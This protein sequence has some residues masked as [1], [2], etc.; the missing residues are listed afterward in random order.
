MERSAPYHLPVELARGTLHRIRNQ[1]AAWQMA[2]L[3]VSVEV[4]DRIDDA[5]QRLARA[6]TTQDAPQA[7]AD[8]AAPCIQASLDIIDEIAA[9]YCQ[10]ALAVRHEP[11]A[12]LATFVAA[13]LGCRPV[14]PNR[15]GVVRDAFNTAVVPLCWSEIEGEDGQ[16]DF[17][18]C[19][20]QIQW[21]R[22]N[23][24]KICGGPLLQFDRTGL[25]DWIQLWDDDFD[26]VLKLAGRWV[27]QIVTRYRGQVNLWQ[28]AARFSAPAGLSLGEQQYLALVVRA[29]ETTRRL[30]P[31]TP[32]VVSFDR[33]FAEH[34]IAKE[35][36][37]SPQAMA[38]TLIRAELGIAGLCLEMNSGFHPGGTLPRDLLQWSFQIDR[39]SMFG[40]PLV[41]VLTAPSSAAQAKSAGDARCISAP[42]SISAPLAAGATPEGQAEW[43]EKT[44]SMLLAKQAV[45]GIVWNQLAD[46]DPHG[47][48]HAGLIDETGSAKPVVQ[49]I[50]KLCQ[51]HL[52]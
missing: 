11:A 17:S 34:M 22:A 25:P 26:R 37:L 42:I 31:R 48:P 12:K 21:C 10:Q 51:E 43:A 20:A 2:G 24:M 6:A 44:V 5:T 8:E 35:H 49:T 4:A 9:S 27:E 29:I 41:V 28:C 52:A 23:G 36:D 50:R 15:A 30:D 16:Y 13:N 47:F 32:V 45:Q 39:W 1:R 46:A 7:S 19:D 14:D 40:L 33:P 3:K 38:D 18:V